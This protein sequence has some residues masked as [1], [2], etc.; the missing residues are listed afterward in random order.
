MEASPDGKGEIMLTAEDKSEIGESLLA[1]VN[2]LY[3]KNGVNADIKIS[4]KS[5]DAS[6]GFILKIGN[7]EYNNTFDALMKGLKE[8]TEGKG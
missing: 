3:S 1:A 6:G 4:D 5:I 8:D 2:E 7:I